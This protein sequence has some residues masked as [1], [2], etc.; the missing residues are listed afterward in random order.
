V[1]FDEM[2]MRYQTEHATIYPMSDSLRPTIVYKEKAKYTAQARTNKV[3]GVVVLSV[4]FGDDLRVKAIRVV[5]GLPYGLTEN[6]I[7]AARRVGFE[8]ARKDGFAVNVR[9]D[10]EFN[11]SLGN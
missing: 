2:M 5:R 10:M 4:V 11:F 9:G 6:A 3:Q 7:A 1:N 8:P